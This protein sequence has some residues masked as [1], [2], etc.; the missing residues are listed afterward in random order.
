ML[1]LLL[2]VAALIVTAAVAAPPHPPQDERLVKRYLDDH[3]NTL[4]A[5]YSLQQYDEMH[6]ND[7]V[8]LDDTGRQTVDHMAQ[9]LK[10]TIE[11]QSND[12][13]VRRLTAIHKRVVEREPRLLLK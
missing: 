4:L 2:V 3:G 1:Y 8:D 7:G 12:E 5:M 13:Q 9:R 6:R 11:R 10:E